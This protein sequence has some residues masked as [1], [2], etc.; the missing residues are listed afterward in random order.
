MPR[1][2]FSPLFASH[3]SR[4]RCAS[5]RLGLVNSASAY[6]LGVALRQLMLEKCNRDS[7]V[8]GQ[9]QLAKCNAELRLR[10]IEHEQINIDSV[11]YDNL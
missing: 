4:T 3:L 5:A 7:V 10:Q 6:G 9:H 2:S 8:F 11:Y 1:G